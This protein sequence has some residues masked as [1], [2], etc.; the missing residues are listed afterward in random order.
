MEITKQELSDLY[1]NNLNE[2]VCEKLGIT[3]ATLRRYLR[4]SGIPLKGSGNRT[5][6]NK[7][8]IT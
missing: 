2:V 5:N 3:Q 7:L 1:H 6:K 4:L 8:V